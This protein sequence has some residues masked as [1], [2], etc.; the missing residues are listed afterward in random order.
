MPIKLHET[1]ENE[2]VTSKYN[3]YTDIKASGYIAVFL[4]LKKLFPFADWSCL[5]SATVGL[6]GRGKRLNHSGRPKNNFGANKEPIFP[7]GKNGKQ[8]S[9]NWI[10]SFTKSGCLGCRDAQGKVTHKSRSGDLVI[11]VIGDEATPTAVGYTEAGSAEDTCAWVLKKE[12]LG[13]DKVGGMLKRINNERKAI[14]SGA[15]GFTNSL[16]RWGAKLLLEATFT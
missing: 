12:H 16:F 6:D 1:Q 14:D 11:L 9:R 8:E 7:G 13:L 10:A 5:F 3:K 4:W 15:G 2:R